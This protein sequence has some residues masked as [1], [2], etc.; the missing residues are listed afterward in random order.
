MSAPSA[1]T[2]QRTSPLVRTL[3][4]TLGLGLAVGMLWW[5][6][7]YFAKTSWSEVLEVLGT[8]PWWKS[9]VF[10]ALVV[11]GLYCYTFVMTGAM[12]GLGHTRALILNVCGSS[13]SNL[14]PGGG[15]V[16]LAAT[17]SIA[18]SW[19]FSTAAVTTMAV[20]T[21]VWN[22]LARAALPII[23]IVGLSW[24]ATDLPS[25]MRDA[26]W[27]AV[28][29]GGVVISLFVLAVATDRGARSLGQGIDRLVQAVRRR[30]TDRVEVALTGMRERTAATVRTGWLSMT[31]GMVGFF[32]LYYV[33]F[34]LCTSTTGI[35]LPF[36][37]L[38]AA[39]AIGRLLTAVGITPGGL[40]VTETGT[41][42][43]LVAWGADPAASMAAVVI[44]S[45]F[46][47]L[48]EIPLGAIGWIAWS[49]MPRA[50][51]EEV[52]AVAD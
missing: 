25:S 1:S 36:G 23:A 43:A 5:G 11:C 20:V 8:V 38:F 39:Y 15:A 34:L 44:F 41:A 52:A 28:V 24:G 50:S 26:A 40:G 6:L 17:F 31:L 30:P 13:V 49:I 18:R 19:G 3:Q 29:T 47:H 9:L 37:Q 45:I 51:A 10:T 48:L 46:T 7:P 21:G 33:L 2:A 35:E 14:L 27:A 22:V 4:V 42:A 32:G 12:P 16:G